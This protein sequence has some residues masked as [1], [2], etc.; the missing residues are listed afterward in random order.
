MLKI[1]PTYDK[2]DKYIVDN[3]NNKSGVSQD[4]VDKYIVDNL[5]NESDVR[6][7][8]QIHRGGGGGLQETFFKEQNTSSLKCEKSFAKYIM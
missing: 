3:L 1:N 2:V 6:Q 4:K 5:N 8:R 7:S